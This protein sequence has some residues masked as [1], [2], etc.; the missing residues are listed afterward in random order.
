MSTYRKTITPK[1]KQLILEKQ[2]YKCANSLYN[3]AIN[4]IDYKCLLWKYENGY[5]DASG[6]DIDHI[7]EVSRSKDNEFENLQA[8]CHNCHAVKTRKF[9]QN[10]TYF[11]STELH[12]GAGFMDVDKPVSKKRKAE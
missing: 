10:K 5:F 4:L 1:I 8:L 12:H 7:N 11:T 2:E 3:P 9:K 6:F